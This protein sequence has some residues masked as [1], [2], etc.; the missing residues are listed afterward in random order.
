MAESLAEVSEL[1]S[2][3]CTFSAT[4]LKTLNFLYKFHKIVALKD[5]ILKICKDE[6]FDENSKEFVKDIKRGLFGY[7]TLLTLGM[8]K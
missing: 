8:I 2:T 3:Y 4:L 6:G 1:F 7:K 5:S